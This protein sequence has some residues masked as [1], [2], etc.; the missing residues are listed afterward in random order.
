M[1]GDKFVYFQFISRYLNPFDAS[2]LVTR[3]VSQRVPILIKD[4]DYN[5]YN[6]LNE[7]AISSLLGKEAAYRC[8]IKNGSR[9]SIDTR[10]VVSHED[11]EDLVLQSQKDLDTTVSMISE[12]YFSFKQSR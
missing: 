9:E 4:N 11:V 12:A 1:D 8:M 5:F 7:H 2:D 10:S 3:V 6:S